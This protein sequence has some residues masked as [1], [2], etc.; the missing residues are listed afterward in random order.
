MGLSES[1]RLEG[2]SLRRQGWRATPW[3]CCV[4]ERCPS[5][6]SNRIPLLHGASVRPNQE[7]SF[8]RPTKSSGQSGSPGSTCG[9]RH[10]GTSSKSNN[11][12]AHT[13]SQ[14]TQHS[15]SA[16]CDTY[17]VDK[18]VTAWGNMALSRR[19]AQ[20]NTSQPY[21][22]MHSLTYVWFQ[23]RRKRKTPHQLPT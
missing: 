23:Q 17:K 5:N 4:G 20:N 10:F 13:R 21:E 14:H 9:E 12:C 8:K 16:K 18:D 11:Q 22:R 1:P 19:P 2:H 15:H 7:L 3:T 6:T